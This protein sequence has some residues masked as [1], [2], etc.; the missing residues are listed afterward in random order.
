MQVKI[1]FDKEVAKKELF[2]GWGLS[3]LIE[4]K[5]LFDVGEKGDYVLK[6]MEVLKVD[7]KK[8][9]KIVISRNQWDHYGGLWDLLD[10][11]KSISVYV[12]SDFIKEFK[13][14]VCNH[15]F[16]EVSS[17]GEIATGIYTTGGFDIMHRKKSVWEQ[18]L[19]VKT[20][21]GVSLICGCAS[22]G[23]LGMI[24]K[25][26][27]FFPQEDIYS[28]IGGFHLMN[29]E[30]RFIKYLAEEIKKIGV[31]KVGPSHCS[32][33]E[34][35]SYFREVFGKDFLEIKVGGEFEI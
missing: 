21:K 31:K 28:I 22:R 16:K 3:F 1:I 13:D 10:I 20:T 34:A 27:D 7:V 5:V 24:R 2:G 11:N 6:N 17:F 29:K 9:E 19:I 8:I 35:I 12:C 14:R 4:N 18:A 30:M 23:I 32:G 33:Y 26:K 25:V 15:T